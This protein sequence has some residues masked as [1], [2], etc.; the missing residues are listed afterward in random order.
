MEDE[1][2][3]EE[4]GSGSDASD[5]NPGWADAIRKILGTKKPKRKKT[6]VLS[7]AKRLCDIKPKEQVE[8]Q[9]FQI[10]GNGEGVVKEES[11][12]SE[13]SRIKEEKEAEHGR[14]KRREAD[15]GIRVKPSPLER[16]RERTLQKIATK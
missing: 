14:R 9:S 2:G 7:K 13:E 10:E 4:E 6:I 11:N 1:S 15:L 12:V 3:D 16:E 5:G 8:N